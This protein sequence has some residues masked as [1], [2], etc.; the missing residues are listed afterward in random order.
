MS[1]VEYIEISSDSDDDDERKYDLSDKI[2]YDVKQEIKMDGSWQSPSRTKSSPDRVEPADKRPRL[3]NSPSSPRCLLHSKKFC[4]NIICV[5][6]E[7]EVK[8]V[9]LQ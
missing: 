5:A 2:T 4:R 3:S 1:S 7:F 8:R 6:K 9:I